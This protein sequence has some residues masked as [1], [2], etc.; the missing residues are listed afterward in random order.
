MYAD[1]RRSRLPIP[2]ILGF[3]ALCSILSLGGA[4]NSAEPSQPIFHSDA[5]SAHEPAAQATEN[6]SERQVSLVELQQ[7]LDA[8]I[9]SMTL[10]FASGG[11]DGPFSW[12]A[13]ICK[14]FKRGNHSIIL[15]GA[16]SS[17]PTVD[18]EE[19]WWGTKQPTCKLTGQIEWG[20]MLYFR[21]EGYAP[22]ELVDV[23]VSGNGYR[24]RYQVRVDTFADASGEGCIPLHIAARFSIVVSPA[25]GEGSFSVIAEG[26]NGRVTA[27]LDVRAPSWPKYGVNFGVDSHPLLLTKGETARLVYA[28]FPPGHR[29]KTVLFRDVGPHSGIHVD[30]GDSFN[31]VGN[32]ESVP[33]GSFETQ[34][35]NR[36]WA[37]VDF[38]WP[39][40][41]GIG[42]YSFSV[43]DVTN[44]DFRAEKDRRRSDPE[45]ELAL[46]YQGGNTVS[47]AAYSVIQFAAR[48]DLT[49]S[50][51]AIRLSQEFWE[52]I[53][54]PRTLPGVTYYRVVNVEDW[55]TLNVR[56]G[57]GVEHEIL[58]KLAWNAG[59]VRVLQTVPVANSSRWANISCDGSYE[60]V[61][62]G[63]GWVNSRF[64]APQQ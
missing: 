3:I 19:L 56:A 38:A 61:G 10:S 35:N 31:G 60:G 55:D 54:V 9:R 63:D 36:G 1:I 53:V 43:P 33:V 28:G 4:A 16:Y 34:V 57:P 51:A 26:S 52:L 6:G 14:S 25:L 13:G 29:V 58:G 22:G 27:D 49:A 7:Q 64:L 47:G 62:K 50:R 15:N 59:Y 5:S 41:L 42:M 37:I 46:V 17:A 12:G 20:D 8:E 48:T 45:Q 30:R 44:L 32:W 21:I 2:T 11:A 24:E 23:T 39:D 40:D 18:L